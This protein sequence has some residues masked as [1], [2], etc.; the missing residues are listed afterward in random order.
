M[1]AC[2]SLFIV[3]G[4]SGGVDRMNPIKQEIEFVAFR[5]CE[6]VDCNFGVLG[7]VCKL[8]VHPIKGALPDMVLGS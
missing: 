6:G 1:I 7:V 8:L 2:I 3:V 5:I 4:D